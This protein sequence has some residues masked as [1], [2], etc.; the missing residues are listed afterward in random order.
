MNKTHR[1]N[2]MLDDED[3]RRLRRIAGRLDW[4]QADT[5]RWLIALGA[6][7]LTAVERERLSAAALAEAGD[8]QD[9][10]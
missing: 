10:F 3:R 2:V 6:A 5:V 9:P 8:E 7:A 1:F 4:T